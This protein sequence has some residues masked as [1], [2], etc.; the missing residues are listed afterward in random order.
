MILTASLTSCLSP[1]PSPE[2]FWLDYEDD[3]QTE[4]FSNQ[5]P[6]GGKRIIHWKNIRGEFDRSDVIQFA[7]ENGWTLQNDS[8]Y[9]SSLTDK[10]TYDNK[11]IFP[12]YFKGFAPQFDFIYSG[13]EDYPRWISGDIR[14]LSFTSNYISIDPG[15]Q[16]EIRTNGFI[17]LNSEQNQMTLYHMWGE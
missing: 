8:I 16:E 1:F 11:P 15:T 4:D 5:G 13:F 17:V 3:Y 7:T 2:G 9:V 6:W 10:W 12:L 14:V